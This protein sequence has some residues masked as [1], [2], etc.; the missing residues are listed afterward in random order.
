MKWFDWKLLNGIKDM[1][2][3]S[4]KIVYMTNK[5]NCFIGHWDA[6]EKCLYHHQEKCLYHHQYDF[7]AMTVE[8]IKRSIEDLIAWSSF[9]ETD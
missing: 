9:P 2:K 1:P 6:S 8:Y 4:Q 3:K 7:D 5:G